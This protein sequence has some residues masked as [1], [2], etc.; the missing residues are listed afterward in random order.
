VGRP[1]LTLVAYEQTEHELQ[2]DCKPMLEIILLPD[3]QWTA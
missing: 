2:M 1:N 3:V